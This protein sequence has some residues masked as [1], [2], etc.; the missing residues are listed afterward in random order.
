MSPLV[1]YISPVK[2]GVW[3][4][5]L[6]WVWGPSRAGECQAATAILDSCPARALAAASWPCTAAAPLSAGLHPPSHP[7]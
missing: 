3:A 2:A 7:P 4:S 6:W 5:I 1:T